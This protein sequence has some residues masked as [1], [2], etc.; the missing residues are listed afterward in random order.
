[1][2]NL[3]DPFSTSDV[4]KANFKILSSQLLQG[5]LNGLRL[6]SVLKLSIS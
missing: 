5:D 3:Q 1:M 2:A 4:L 6:H